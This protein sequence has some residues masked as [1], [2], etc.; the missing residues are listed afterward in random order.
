MAW[1]AGFSVLSVIG[2]LL[3]AYSR[4]EDARLLAVALVGLALSAWPAWYGG[5]LYLLAPL[6]A[7]MWCVALTMWLVRPV[8]WLRDFL[9]VS[10]LRVALHVAIGLVPSMAATPFFHLLNAAFV[11]QVFLVS[12]QGGIRLGHSCSDRLRSWGR[13]FPMVRPTVAREA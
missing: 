9:A 2:L 11:A 12:R 8:S 3:A 6:D 10:A 1:L 13:L 5:V 4:D 7:L